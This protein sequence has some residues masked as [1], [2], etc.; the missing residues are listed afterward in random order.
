MLIERTEGK[1]IADFVEV[2]GL[3]KIA[4]GEVVA[5]LSETQSRPVLVELAELALIQMGAR[6]FHVRM[7]TPRL[8]SPI[9][10]RSTGTSLAIGGLEQVVRTLASCNVVIDCTVEGL[11]HAP[12][13]TGILSQGARIF[14][15]SNEHPEI[16]ER[17]KP[18]SELQKK[19]LAGAQMITD[20]SRMEVTSAAGTRLT[21]DL[22][23]TPGRGSAGIADK[24]GS[25]GYWP[26]GLCLCFPRPGSVNG[27]LVLAP[28]D[29]NLTFKRY[30]ETRI[31]LHVENDYV[32]SIEGEGT[33]A[34][35]M[36]SYY[37]S[38]NDPEAYAVSHVGWGMAP[39]ARWDSLTMYD[40]RDTNGTELRAF[41][42]NFLF[43]T[44]ANE[45]AGRFTDCHFDYPMRHCSVRLDDRLVVDAG[46][47]TEGLL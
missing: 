12:E 45:T 35:L 43:S 5:I 6:V 32:V 10:L 22:T 1:W 29:V 36:R 25:F 14:M 46:K 28:G 17:L 7:P 47:L 24:P 31:T 41:A 34:Q 40:K 15:I 4:P 23:G 21:V 26:A 3:C 11:L 13:R 2:F 16:L 37:E 44:G 8:N 42:G 30:L 33:D 19:C 39:A 18:S 27:T 9:P 38:W 20:A